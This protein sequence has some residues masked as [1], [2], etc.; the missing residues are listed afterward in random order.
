MVVAWT[1]TRESKDAAVQFTLLLTVRACGRSEAGCCQGRSR[2]HQHQNSSS[3][4]SRTTT[5]TKT[6]GSEACAHTIA[7]TLR[8]GV[9]RSTCGVSEHPLA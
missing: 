2:Q 3:P 5:T 7:L 4:R 9:P 1:N 8:R 6:R